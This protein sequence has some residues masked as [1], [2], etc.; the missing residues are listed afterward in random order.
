VFSGRILYIFTH[1][2]TQTQKLQQ[3]VQMNYSLKLR[4]VI[5]VL[6][7]VTL[8]LVRTIPQP[9]LAQ[10]LKDDAH[11]SVL[12][13]FEPATFWLL[14]LSLNSSPHHYI[15][16]MFYIIS[17]MQYCGSNLWTKRMNFTNTS[18]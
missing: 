1:T 12:L 6:L 7:V 17:L 3:Q 5:S 18:L 2:H 16:M 15:P 9:G 13:E 4:C 8:N 14:A 11:G 10:G